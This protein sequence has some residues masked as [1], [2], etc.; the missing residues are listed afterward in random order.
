VLA[1]TDYEGLGAPGLHPYIVGESEA[2]GVLDIVRTLPALDVGASDDVIVWGHSQ[3]GHAA[4]HSGQTWQDWAPELN[5]VGVVAGAPPSQFA[6][7]AGVLAD[8]DFQGYVMMTAAGL[9]AAYPELDLA[10]V[11]SEEALEL[12][13]VLDEGCTDEVFDVYNPI[14]YDELVAVE[15]PFGVEP[16]ATRLIENDTNQAPVPVPLLI[17][18]GGEDEQ[19]PVASSEILLGQ[20][21]A[22]EG[23]ASVER[24]VYEGANHSGAVEAS[25]D[26]ML[27]WMAARFAGEPAGDDCP[28]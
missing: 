18:H 10:E 2:R 26:E 19:I 21:C 14:P 12:V 9:A 28:A 11:A 23:S 4:V 27:A 3:G 15:D 24:N 20:L 8:G 13:G 17:I 22:L 16:W 1:A 25:I 7:L 5:L 6:F